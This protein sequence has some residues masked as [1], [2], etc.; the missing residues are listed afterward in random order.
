MTPYCFVEGTNVTKVTT[1]SIFKVNLRP[2][3]L[4][5]I[6]LTSCALYLALF[7]YI[8]HL[9]HKPGCHI[10]VSAS[11]KS[12]LLIGKIFCG[13]CTHKWELCHFSAS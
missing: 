10:K 9:L 6:F 11:S 1:D 2:K 13:Y 3:E 7:S 5:Y 8:V 4:L 12:R